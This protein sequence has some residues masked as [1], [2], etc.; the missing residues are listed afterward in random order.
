M[1]LLF[2]F[3]VV[4]KISNLPIL[5]FLFIAYIIRNK[6]IIKCLNI[7]NII[8]TLALLVLPFLVYLIYNVIE[9]GNPVFPFYNTIFSSK[10]FSIRNWLDTRFGPHKILEVLL[11]PIVALR[12]PIR[13][14][15]IAIFEPIWCYGYIIAILYSIYYLFIKIIKKKEVDNN[16][17]FF[18]IST[19]IVYLLWS[20]FQLGYTRYGFI[21][22]ILGSIS[23][24]IL[25]YD[26]VKN[27]KYFLLGIMSILTVYNIGYSV[28]NYMFKHQ[29]WIYNNYYNS[30][31]SYKYNIKKLLSKGD[32]NKIEFEKDSVWGII[33]ENAGL[34]QAINTDIPI[35]NIG[36]SADNKYT[37]KLLNN[38]LKKASHIYSL[39]DTIDFENYIN[40]LNSYNYKITNIKYVFNSDLLCSDNYFVYIFEIE[41]S[42]SKTNYNKFYDEI[43]YDA[44]L[45]NNKDLN[46]GIFKNDDSLDSNKLSIIGIKDDKEVVVDTV[47]VK[48][49]GS[50]ITLNYDTSEYNK[51]KIVA[52][53]KT[54]AFITIY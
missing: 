48:K 49:D 31:C 2:G 1:A 39:V 34:A 26:L 14:C 22:L 35:I 47:S 27:K 33:Y 16:R 52:E 19:V 18:F 41:K 11:Y 42:D 3:A 45:L 12:N 4:T 37:K 50:M 30:Y 36:Q 17:L 29:D 15:D 40:A 44:S 54:Q 13:S 51:I 5:A 8:S 10:Y 24:Y 7:K 20:N 46:I 21:T 6:S 23:F 32:E 25:I 43:E 53:E 28:S 9:T 38:K